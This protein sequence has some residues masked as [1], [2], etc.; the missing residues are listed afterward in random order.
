MALHVYGSVKNHLHRLCSINDTFLS[1]ENGIRKKKNK[2]GEKKSSAAIPLT[3]GDNALCS[4]RPTL[5]LF[6][7]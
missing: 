6:L 4:T 3:E 1:K 2:K 7:F 5:V